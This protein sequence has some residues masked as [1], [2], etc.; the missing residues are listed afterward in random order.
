MAHA[1]GEF[2]DRM[3]R[4]EIKNEKAETSQGRDKD[5]WGFPLEHGHVYVSHGI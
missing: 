3:V 2:L 5:G 4:L 1:V